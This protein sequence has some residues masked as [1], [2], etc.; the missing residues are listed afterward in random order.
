MSYLSLKPS[1]AFLISANYTDGLG[2]GLKYLHYHEN[3]IPM[4]YVLCIFV[5]YSKNKTA[6]SPLLMDRRYHS[7]APSH[8]HMNHITLCQTTNMITE[9]GNILKVSAS[10]LKAFA[11]LHDG[12]KPLPGPKS[13][14]YYESNVAKKRC[15]RPRQNGCHF[16][17]DIFKYIFLNGN[18][19]I[20]IEIPLKFVPNGPMNNSRS[21]VQIIWPNDN[22]LTHIWVTRHLMS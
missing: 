3:E 20:S 15:V 7:F 12:S 13:T 1:G 17:E 8:Q 6:L 9:I 19:W 21:L 10:S 18:V 5:L 16:P 22:L 14:N 4:D 11:L 2:Q